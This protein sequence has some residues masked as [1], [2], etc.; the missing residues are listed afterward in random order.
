VHA[1]EHLTQT[2]NLGLQRNDVALEL[3]I[4]LAQIDVLA[5]DVPLVSPGH[6][7]R[8]V[9]TCK[10]DGR[11]GSRAPDAFQGVAKII[12]VERRAGTDP[13]IGTRYSA[14]DANDRSGFPAGFTSLR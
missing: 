9:T 12:S 13:P 7:R 6:G 1:I 5:F 11:M 4:A 2:L 10:V 3:R 8:Q 14:G